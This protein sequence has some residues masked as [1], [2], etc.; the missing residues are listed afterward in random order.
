MNSVLL[1]LGSKTKKSPIIFIIQLIV[2]V[3]IAQLNLTINHNWGDDFAAYIA[4]TE[5]LLNGEMGKYTVDNTYSITQSSFLLG[6][7]YY[8]WGTSIL[9]SPIFH[10]I[11]NNLFYLK[12]IVIF[13]YACFLIV[14]YIQYKKQF[15]PFLLIFFISF[16][17]FN[18]CLI[19][20]LD[21][22]GSDIPFLMISTLTIYFIEIWCVDKC[23]C[24]EKPLYGFIIV[25]FAFFATLVR[26]NGILLFLLFMICNLKILIQAFSLKVSKIKNVYNFF[27]LFLW[28]LFWLILGKLQNS[29][30][31]FDNIHENV[32]KGISLEGLETNFRYYVNTLSDFFSGSQIDQKIVMGITIPFCVLGI[33]ATIK[34]KFH[35]IIYIILTFALYVFWPIQ[36]GFR[37]LF[38]ILPLYI[39]YL[40][41]GIDFSNF[42]FGFNYYKMGKL[43]SILFLSFIVSCFFLNIFFNSWRNI[44]N[45]RIQAGPFDNTSKELCLFIK[46]K[47]SLNDVIVF[48]K[49]RALRLMLHE[50]RKIKALDKIP[51]LSPKDVLIL[52]KTPEF[53][54]INPSSVLNV[55]Y[56]KKTWENT[57]FIVYKVN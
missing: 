18:P 45:N 10:L 35:Y 53:G 32:I 36:G 52:K 1:K 57:E 56:L 40:F 55:R 34:N 15:N 33:T 2:F 26:N 4:Q 9:L 51:L 17:S 37:F 44:K 42:G 7:I 24:Y 47:I 39:Y 43:F 20:Y 16:F 48:C 21:I 6:P 54:Q 23:V 11:G 25:L 30:L 28:C 3:F 50:S 19:G 5:I 46:E 27:I 22:I 29:L 12:F 41:K 38:P 13:C 8:P 14:L 49:P 31:P